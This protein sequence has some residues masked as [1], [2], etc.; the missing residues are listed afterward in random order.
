MS[1]T[2]RP[3]PPRSAEPPIM[4]GSGAVLRSLEL[5]GV[6]DGLE[7]HQVLIAVVDDEPT[8]NK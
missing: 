6:E 1:I 5:L 7:R 2:P 4:T 8:D 3:A